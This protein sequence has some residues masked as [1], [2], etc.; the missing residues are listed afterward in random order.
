V[1]NVHKCPSGEIGNWLKTVHKN[2]HYI[3]LSIHRVTY[4][5]ESSYEW[6]SAVCNLNPAYNG[7][8][9]VS[10]EKIGEQTTSNDH[11]DEM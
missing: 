10:T 6:W 3:C 9:P 8:P 2:P 1:T 11:K 5:G 7:P 4:S